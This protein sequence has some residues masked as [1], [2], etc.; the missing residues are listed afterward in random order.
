M[1]K[2][3][4]DEVCREQL[5]S[6]MIERFEDD[7]SIIVFFEV[8]GHDVDILTRL[9][10]DSKSSDKP[11]FIVANTVK[12]KGVSFME[13]QPSWHSRFPTAAEQESMIKELL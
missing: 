3:V 1:K 10:S 8:D 9:L 13:N 7:L 11:T 2:K 5:G 4:F 12:G 6:A